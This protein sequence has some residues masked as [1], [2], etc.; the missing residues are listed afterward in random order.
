MC[1]TF[2]RLLLKLIGK[3]NPINI[4]FA[5][6]SALWILYRMVSIFYHG[7]I[8]ILVTIYACMNSTHPKLRGGHK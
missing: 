4:S 3:L 2:D 6:Y 7:Q 5:H 1:N 8:E